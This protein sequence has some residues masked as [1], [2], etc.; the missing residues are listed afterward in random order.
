MWQGPFKM[1]RM[2]RR[3]KAIRACFERTNTW[4]LTS[5]VVTLIYL[6]DPTWTNFTGILALCISGFHCSYYTILAYFEYYN[7]ITDGF[8][9]NCTEK[10]YRIVK[11]SRITSVSTDST[12]PYQ[13]FQIQRE[14]SKVT[15]SSK[16]LYSTSLSHIRSFLLKHYIKKSGSLPP[17]LSTF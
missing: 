16:R 8:Y 9:R 1:H 5:F 10:K 12:S 13:H 14:K 15:L 3:F 17:D 11:Q 6:Q 2:F 4:L 7:L